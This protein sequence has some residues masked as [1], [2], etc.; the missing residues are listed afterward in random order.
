MAISSEAREILE[1]MSRRKV[2]PHETDMKITP[3]PDGMVL[4][5]MSITD[6]FL[7]QMILNLQNELTAT[8]KLLTNL[9]NDSNAD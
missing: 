1:K 8:N 4:H 9:I 7:A 6:R 3:D 5:E 2:F